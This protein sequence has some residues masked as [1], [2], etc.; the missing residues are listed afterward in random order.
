MWGESFEDGGGSLV[1]ERS[2]EEGERGFV[3]DGRGGAWSDPWSLW[4]V[5]DGRWEECVGE[6]GIK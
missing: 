1:G 6:F 4:D 3:E 2:R 5:G